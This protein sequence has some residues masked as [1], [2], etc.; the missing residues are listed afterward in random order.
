[1]SENKKTGS[2]YTPPEIIRFMVEYLSMEKQDFNEVLEPSAG[3]GRFIEEL[4]KYSKHITAIE[5]FADKVED[6]QNRYYEEKVTVMQQNFLNYALISLEKFS[7]IIGNPP[8]ISMKTMETEERDTSKKLCELQNYGTDIMQNMW[9]AFMIGAARMLTPQGTIFFVLPTEF[10]QVQYAEKLREKLEILFDTIHIINF[11]EAV[12][13]E[14]EQDVCL[15]YLSNRGNNTPQIVYKMFENWLQKKVIKETIIRKNKPLKKWSNAILS[16]TEISLL[17]EA[18]NKYIKIKELGDIAPGIVTGGNKYFILTEAQVNQY[19]CKELVI[20]IIQKSSYIESDKIE[21]SKNVFDN[22]RKKGKPI[23]LL[24]LESVKEAEIPL[25]LSIYLQEIGEEKTA[26]I[27][28]KD[29]YKCAN[30]KPWYGIPIVKK[31]EVVFFKRY[32]QYP[33]IYINTEFIHTTD[34]G[35]HIR[36]KEKYDAD[37]VVFCFFNS[38]TLAH[39]EFNGRY[40]GGGVC[41]LVPSEFKRVPL[42]YRTIAKRDV[43]ALKKMFNNKEDIEKIVKYVNSKTIC[44]D[45]KQ[46]SD[47]FENIR[48]QLVERRI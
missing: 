30:R 7:L 42:P 25:E 10:L 19:R 32:G 21:I 34:A 36:L 26:D 13:P 38:M 28:L 2:Y 37:S 5:K 15:V 23:Y 41:E 24:D 29:R 8:Y 20:P 31:G 22:I 14:I 35:Y 27:A 39:C 4:L 46:E 40:Y 45:F 48:K 1:M 11:R 18:S 9:V 6:I 12:F 43:D 3:D 33:K 16:D 44:L 17:K 47:T